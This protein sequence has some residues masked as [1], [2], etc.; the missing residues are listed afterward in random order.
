MVCLGDF[1]LGHV[2]ISPLDL[3]S[4]NRTFGQVRTGQAR[5]NY[6]RRVNRINA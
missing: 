3:P 2:A 4:L 1:P 5:R 6:T